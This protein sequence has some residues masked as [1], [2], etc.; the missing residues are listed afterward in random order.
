[1][2]SQTSKRDNVCSTVRIKESVAMSIE[3]KLKNAKT[4]SWLT[5]GLSDL[6][7]QTIKCKT[8]IYLFLVRIY[9]GFKDFVKGIDYD[10]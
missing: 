6:E 4:S 1:M 8:A 10:T 9:I 3:S 5:D 2:V 7:L